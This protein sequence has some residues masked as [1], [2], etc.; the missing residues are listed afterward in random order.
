VGG[1]GDHLSSGY[2][3]RWAD[4]LLRTGRPGPARTL[5]I[6]NI[7]ICQE[8]GWNGVLAKC[9]RLLGRLALAAGDTIT[10]AEYLAAAATCLR[11]G[12]YLIELAVTGGGARLRA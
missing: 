12:D 7:E 3:T 9:H 4:R 8:F 1:D 10:A 6:R 5:T 11:D 2:G